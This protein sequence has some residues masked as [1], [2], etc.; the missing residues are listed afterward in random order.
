MIYL[1]HAATSPMSDEAIHTYCETARLFTGNPSSLH[2]TGS[3]AATLLEHCREKLAT[4]INAKRDNIYFTSGGTESNQRIIRSLLKPYRNQRPHIITS[5]LEHASTRTLCQELKAEN[6]EV[7]FIDIDKSGHIR[8]DELEAAIQPNTILATL[9][10]VNGDIGTIQPVEKAVSLLHQYNVKLHCDAVQAYGK[11]PID[12]T[13]IP[14]DA[15]SVSAHKLGGPK[16]IGFAYLSENVQW[17]SLER[18]TTHERGFRPGTVD[19]PSVASFTDA[20]TTACHNIQTNNKGVSALRD[21][22]IESLKANP[23]IVIES[24]QSSSSPYIVGFRIKEMDGTVAM[25]YMNRYGVAVSTGSA[26]QVQE[27][28][29]AET[30]TALG[31][32]RDEAQQF[33]RISLSP[34]TTENEVNTFLDTLEKLIKTRGMTNGE[35]KE[36]AR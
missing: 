22:I 32:S 13:H 29:P 21:Q 4:T 3:K 26:C 34:S 35:T 5:H 25:L 33:I 14:I 23:A 18:G 27:D 7:S 30:L 19:I 31:R 12:V 20:A 15:L 16:G 24:P 9:P 28:H 6:I 10:F 1:D 2:D 11:L 36:V 17:E 8:L